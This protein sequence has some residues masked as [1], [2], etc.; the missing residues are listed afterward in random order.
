MRTKFKILMCALFLL[1]FAVSQV[2]AQDA[3]RLGARTQNGCSVR[4][5]PDGG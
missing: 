5:Q 1:A 4:T 2:H 3:F